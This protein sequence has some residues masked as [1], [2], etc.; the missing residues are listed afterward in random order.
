MM[1]NPMMQNPMMQQPMPQQKAA[2]PKPAEEVKATEQSMINQS[3]S[4]MVEVLQN[5]SN[6]KHRNSEFLKFLLKLNSGAL[7]IKNDTDLIVNAEKMKEFEAKEVVR[8]EEEVK[9]QAEEEEFRKQHMEYMKKLEEE[10]D[11]DEIDDQIP[12]G[13]MPQSQMMPGFGLQQEE[14]KWEEAQ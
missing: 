14:K 6:P 2:E 11:V 12:Q 10:G 3:S 9:K 13:N 8:M 4:N 7:E 1:F 5:S